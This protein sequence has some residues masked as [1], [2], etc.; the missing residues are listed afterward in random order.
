MPDEDDG[1]EEREDVRVEV[2]NVD[3]EMRAPLPA[4]VLHGLPSSPCYLQ[5]RRVPVVRVFGATP[6]GQKA[7]VHIHGVSCLC[8]ALT[9]KSTRT[10]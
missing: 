2:V 9:D 6:A 3:Y 10:N 5:A 7:L 1:D 8:L 4:G